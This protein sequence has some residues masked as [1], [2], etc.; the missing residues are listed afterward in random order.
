MT[1]AC[2]MLV[3][4]DCSDSIKDKGICSCPCHIEQ[5]EKKVKLMLEFIQLE[6]K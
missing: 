6:E 5:A 1:G 4:Q 2:V 3:H